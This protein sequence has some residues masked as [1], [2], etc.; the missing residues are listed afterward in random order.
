MNKKEI[1]NILMSIRTSDNEKYV[2]NLLGKIDLLSESK[3]ESIVAQIGDNE[4]CIKK[5]LQENLMQGHEEFTPINELFSY[6]ISDNAIHLHLPV[7]LHQ[8]MSEKGIRKTIDTVNLYLLDAI[9]RIR[10]MRQEGYYKF[11]EKDSVY[12]L[13]P[14]LVNREREFLNELG[15][16]TQVYKKH[17]LQNE[18]FVAEHKEALLANIF[19][20]K[21][22][23]VGVAIIKLDKTNSKQ[24][25]EKR[26]EVIENFKQ[27]G[28]TLNG[29][30]R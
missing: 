1:K 22:K 26:L 4:E 21:D 5:Y 24:W 19:F 15:F 25:Q 29:E 30:E 27:N 23:N 9:E 10:K 2:N 16:E 14:L 12:M 6:G 18:Q 13:S 7:D 11:T 8:M 28:I 17:E 3:L 20:G